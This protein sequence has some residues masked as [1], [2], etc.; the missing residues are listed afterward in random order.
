MKILIKSD[1][2][3]ICN[4]VK[5]FDSSYRIVYD[6]ASLKYL[7][8]STKL[9]KSI[10]LIGWMP[11]SYVCS[12]PYS[13]LDARVI[14]YLYQTSVNNIDTLISQIDQ[15]NNQLE[16]DSE[17]KVKQQVLINAENTLRQLS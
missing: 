6:T 15:L 16:R 8:Y 13:Q 11:L 5:Q 7:I 4:R 17:L 12:L 14:A 1:V 10:E 3:N 9:G 2:Y